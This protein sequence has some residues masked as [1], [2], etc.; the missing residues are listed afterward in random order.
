MGDGLAG[1]AVF[2]LE[3]GERQ[4]VDEQ[5]QVERPAGG[6]QRIAELP[7]YGESIGG[8]A[9]GRRSCCL[10]T[11]AE[12]TASP[13]AGRGGRRTQN[14]DYAARCDLVP[15]T[16]QK[17]APHRRVG[18]DRQRVD[19]VGLGCM[20][21]SREL[22]EVKRVGPVVVVPAALDI[23]VGAGKGGGVL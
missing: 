14:I 3:G 5:A 19:K 9:R 20:D 22:G 8:E 13:H 23:V 4:A 16:G 15:H 1:Q 7:R 10:V 11:G 18:V 12:N 21:E 2:Q 17:G 6:I